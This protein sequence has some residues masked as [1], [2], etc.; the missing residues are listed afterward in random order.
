MNMQQKGNSDPSIT[1]DHIAF[2][3]FDIAWA[4]ECPWVPGSGYCF[5]SENG[6]IRFI[7]LDGTLIGDPYDVA[8]S[9]ESV[10]GVAFAADLMAVSTRRDV[11]FFSVPRLGQGQVERAVFHGGAFDVVAMPRGGFV[12]PLGRNGLLVFGEKQ[13]GS[14]KVKTLR[15]GAEGFNLYRVAPLASAPGRGDVLACAARDDGFAIMTIGD[16]HTI[17]FGRRLRAPGVDFVDACSLESER[18]PLGAA[19]LGLDGSIHLTYD[20]LRDQSPKTLRFRGIKGR[21]YRIFCHRG[22]IV[23]LTSDGVYSFMDLGARFL[24]GESIDGPTSARRLGLDP[25]DATLTSEGQLLVLM[26]DKVIRIGI[27]TLIERD[28]DPNRTTNADSAS[29]AAY[30]NDESFGEFDETV[31]AQ[32]NELELTPP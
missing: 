32:S 20:A 30:V 27:D 9:R 25:V 31:W 7:G 5:G 16:E 17:T 28:G 19:A 4:G 6:E 18:F 12:A 23:L 15:A 8:P 14:Q 3:D 1:V 13:T 29:L 26:S 10:N 2:S 22:H 11:T 21:G 24:N